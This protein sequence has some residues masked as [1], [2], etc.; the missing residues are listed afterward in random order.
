[1]YKLKSPFSTGRRVGNFVACFL[2]M[3]VVFAVA[4]AIVLRE[5]KFYFFMGNNHFM[6]KIGWIQII[7]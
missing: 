6:N 4:Y 7:D 3:D 1:M 2:M 5:L